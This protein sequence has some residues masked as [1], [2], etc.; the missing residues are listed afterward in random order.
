VSNSTDETNNGE[1]CTLRVV[2]VVKTTQADRLID[3]AG[4][5]YTLGVATTGEP[6]AVT[7][8]GANVAIPFRGDDSGLRRSLAAAYHDTH[9]GAPSNAALSDALRVL[10]GKADRLE[11]QEL[12]VRVGRAGDEIVVDVGDRAGRALVVSQSGWNLIDRSPIAFRRASGLSDALPEPSRGG[13][14]FNDLANVLGLSPYGD[15]IALLEGWC[16]A[17]LVP[18]IAH[19]ILCLRGEQGSGKSTIARALI[20]LVDPS[21]AALRSVPSLRDWHT[22]AKNQ[23]IVGLDN[24]SR[25]SEAEANLLCTAVTG[26]A[27]VTRQLY[28][29]DATF[30]SAYRRPVVLTSIGLGAIRGDLADRMLTVD[31]PQITPTTRRTENEI[32]GAVTEMRP[33]LLAA[34]L[35]DVSGVLKFRI[36]AEASATHRPR[37]ADYADLMVALDLSRGGLRRF[38]PTYE[39][40][41]GESAAD[42]V[43]GDVFVAAVRDHM[44]TR[45]VVARGNSREFNGSISE[46]M[47][48]CQPAVCPIDW[49]RSGAVASTR[50][51]TAQPALR[52]L[53]IAITRS[54]GHRGRVLNITAT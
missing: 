51:Q 48:A 46:L 31:L 29:D 2:P 26:D 22:S 53:G 23:W 42:V 18:D 34:L 20:G 9:G 24:V 36:Q 10:A 1:Q 6:F 44:T 40:V 7:K 30:V 32:I 3:L 14:T 49:P 35:D 5:D 25:V 50:L 47:A 11:P 12:P 43:D 41:A 15:E 28:S 19:P 16:A 13:A 17:A 4:R 33:G 52:A 27:Y 21:P 54:R 45:A 8:T 39:R 37:M 38:A